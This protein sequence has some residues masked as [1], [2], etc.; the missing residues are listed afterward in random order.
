MHRKRGVSGEIDAFSALDQDRKSKTQQGVTRDKILAAQANWDAEMHHT[1]VCLLTALLIA[2]SMRSSP[3][4]SAMFN[5]SGGAAP[6][7][8]QIGPRTFGSSPKG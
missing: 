6:G 2:D 7:N 8:A 5:I 4:P 1:A 3:V